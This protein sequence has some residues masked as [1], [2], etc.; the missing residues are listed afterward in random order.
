[1]D[2]INSNNEQWH[3][4]ATK[5]GGDMRRGQAKPAGPQLEARADSGDELLGQEQRAANPSQPTRSGSAVSSHSGV[6]GCYLAWKWSVV[7]TISAQ[8]FSD[9]ILKS[10][11]N[12]HHHSQKWW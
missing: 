5:S 8:K 1:M 2:R 9:C 7:V 4:F 10:G 6:R 11:G 3:N 12:S